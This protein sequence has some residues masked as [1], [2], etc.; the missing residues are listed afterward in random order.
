MESGGLELGRPRAR[1]KKRNAHLEDANQQLWRCVTTD[2][3]H[4]QVCRDRI[5]CRQHDLPTS[6]CDH[7]VGSDPR[8]GE[9]RGAVLQ[10][11]PVV[12]Q[13]LL[14]RGHAELRLEARLHVRHCLSGI[15][16]DLRELAVRLRVDAEADRHLAW[17]E[18]RWCSDGFAKKNE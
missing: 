16:L 8:C 2:V 7:V 3:A 6:H 12:Q 15:H 13:Q 9:R 17:G 14:E 11:L 5:A 10:L 1:Q 18:T 4:A